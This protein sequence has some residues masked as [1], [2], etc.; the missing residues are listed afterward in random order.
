MP[1][2]AA[3]INVARR[4]AHAADEGGVQRIDRSKNDQHQTE[5]LQT[6]PPPWDPLARAD[7]PADGGGPA[8]PA[9][10][11]WQQLRSS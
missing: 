5:E 4:V 7:A 1:T 11:R 2:G 3:Q 10:G 6:R 9:G 8:A